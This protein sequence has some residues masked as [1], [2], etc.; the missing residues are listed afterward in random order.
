MVHLLHVKYIM[1]SVYGLRMCLKYLTIES[2]EKQMNI[3]LFWSDMFYNVPV[4]AEMCLPVISFH[5][6]TPVRLPAAGESSDDVFSSSQ[7]LATD[8]LHDRSG[9][10]KDK[11]RS[12]EIPSFHLSRV[13]YH[14]L[15]TLATGSY[16]SFHIVR[17]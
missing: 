10:T 11:P 7:M 4:Q 8:G 14:S 1:P 6:L 5:T 9:A 3:A 2:D 12:P 13:T 17:N 15:A 16:Y